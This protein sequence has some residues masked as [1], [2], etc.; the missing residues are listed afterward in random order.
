MSCAEHTTGRLI[1]AI[2][3]VTLPVTEEAAGNAAALVV[4]LVC[5]ALHVLGTVQLI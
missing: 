1:T 4:T 5:T 3:A 2:F